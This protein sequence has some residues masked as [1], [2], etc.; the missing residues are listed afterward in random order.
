MLRGFATSYGRKKTAMLALFER[1]AALDPYALEQIRVQ[2][3]LGGSVKHPRKEYCLKALTQVSYLAT[4]S[5]YDS[6]RPTHK[7]S[8]RFHACA[9]HVPPKPR[10]HYPPILPSSVRLTRFNP[11]QWAVH[12]LG[13]WMTSKPVP[14]SCLVLCVLVFPATT[15]ANPSCF[16]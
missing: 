15:C 4:L 8:E 5:L 3:L 1:T 7:R 14:P 13:F 12:T 6:Q 11:S 16:Y 9:C 2:D 10:P